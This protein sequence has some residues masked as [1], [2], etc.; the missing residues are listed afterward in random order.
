M[1]NTWTIIPLIFMVVGA[2]VAQE[3]TEQVSYD[4]MARELANPNTSMASL[5]LKSQFTWFDGA[6]PKADRQFGS[7]L[8]FQPVLPFPLKNGGQI[9][10]RP[11]VPFILD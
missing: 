5:T 4:D 11:A 1:K 3:S 8:L 10:L 6:L 9:M 7:T 2:V